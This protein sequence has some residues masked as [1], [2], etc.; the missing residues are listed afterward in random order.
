MKSPSHHGRAKPLTWIYFT[1][2]SIRHFLCL[3]TLAS[4]LNAQSLTEQDCTIQ[5]QDT[6]EKILNWT[7]HVGRTYFIQSSPD[8]IDWSWAPN[9]EAGENRPMS[10]EVDGPTNAGFY[11]LQYTDLTAPNLE[12]AD[13]DGDGL[14]NLAEITQRPRPTAA[15][16]N[17]SLQATSLQSSSALPVQNGTR[18]ISSKSTRATLSASI[19]TNPLKT[20]T[21]G[22][23]L[24]DKW[25]ED[26]QLDPTDDGSNN[27]NSGPNGDP[28]Q[29]DLDNLS[30]IQNGTDPMNQD[31]DGDGASDSDDYHSAPLVWPMIWT[32][33]FI[34]AWASKSTSFFREFEPTIPSGDST[35]IVRWYMQKEY[36]YLDEQSTSFP[37][38]YYDSWKVT[39]RVD[40]DSR[41]VTSWVT[42]E[43]REQGQ[44]QW[45]DF[46]N[47][48]W[49]LESQSHHEVTKTRVFDESI[50]HATLR[51][52]GIT[53]VQTWRAETNLSDEFTTAMLLEDLGERFDELQRERARDPWNFG[54][55]GITG[56][57]SFISRSEEK[58]LKMKC[59]YAMEPP[60]RPASSD[61]RIAWLEVS[62]PNPYRGDIAID[63][64]P[65]PPVVKLYQ[66]FFTAARLVQFNRP[67]DS[68][69]PAFPKTTVHTLSPDQN[70][71][72]KVI[73]LACELKL[74]HRL[75]TLVANQQTGDAMA[76]APDWAASSNGTLEWSIS[77]TLGN[78]PPANASPQNTD[79]L[80]D[81]FNVPIR[82]EVI[83][84][85]ENIRLA[86]RSDAGNGSESFTPVT[87][88]IADLRE[89]PSGF[90]LQSTGPGRVV[91][92]ASL[93]TKHGLRIVSTTE[94][95]M[96]LLDL[97]VDSDNSGEIDGSLA[98]DEMEADPAQPGKLLV[99]TPS[100]GDAPGSP[101]S[102]VKMSLKT[103]SLRA[104]D[105]VQFNYDDDQMTVWN[106]RPDQNPPADQRVVGRGV[107]TLAELGIVPGTPKTFYISPGQECSG[108][109]LISVHI[110]AANANNGTS[111]DEVAMNF[112]PV[113]V[114]MVKKGETT[115]P[116]DGL[117]VKKTDTVRYRL[118]PGLPDAPL[119]LEDKIQWHWR[120]LKW[121]GTYGN[122]TA[123]T[124]G[125]GHTFTAQPQDAGIY[126]V[127]ATMEGQDFFLKRAKDD[128]HSAKKKDEN[129]CFGVVDQDWQINVRNQAKANLGSVAYA[130]AVAND[131]V[132]EDQYK[133]NLFVGHKATDG[134]AIVPKINGNNPFNTY[135]PIANQWAGTQ[136]VNIP[137]WVL[138]PANT[139]PQPGY[140]VARGVA[141]GT[142]HTGIVDYDGAWIGA[143]TFNVNRNADLRNDISLRSGTTTYQPARFH[144]YTP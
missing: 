133:C 118:S 41:E 44:E 2:L 48:N 33:S 60:A 40:P 26:H 123:Y 32:H 81:E 11:R 45:L 137:G 21:D 104:S 124:N 19:Q 110:I 46:N 103:I 50:D 111:S 30:E 67:I 5:L 102:W 131:N 129:E 22:D 54:G 8:L 92:R 136:V 106:S 71:E 3:I 112:V 72:M 64:D 34:E 90:V 134:G 51:T 139:Y 140:V 63:D 68:S 74:D 93:V 29:D 7:G 53:G 126:E 73:P 56:I 117:I 16:R 138:L 76:A 100:S 99:Y 58:A 105:K 25:E 84:G 115:A 37:T 108:R 78:R 39:Y 114:K 20:D 6:G 88:P 18:P 38:S 143:G 42:R 75:G 62:E 9:I 98:E 10:Y 43:P 13:F 28:D 1:F 83:E 113:E 144:K 101:E 82:L 95:L 77:G 116:E 85:A 27:P 107:Y 125:K 4:T 17:Q 69:Q 23:G 109:Q 97:D 57:T 52:I 122:W 127:K 86:A 24:T 135:Y 132:D 66:E 31:T 61:V 79:V 130:F 59:D 96:G 94:G 12:A 15:T 120:I 128:S 80:W 141:G 35:P 142:G 55:S 70:Q 91:I 87:L 121:D 14:S 36:S 89:Y 119:L 49:Y 65:R 47:G